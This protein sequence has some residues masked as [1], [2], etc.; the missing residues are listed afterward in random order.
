MKP[1]WT[2]QDYEAAIKKRVRGGVDAR[3][4]TVTSGSRRDPAIQKTIS[5]R[6][7]SALSPF[8]SKLEAQFAQQLESDV[9]AGIIGNFW[10]EPVSFKL[11]AGKRYRPDFMVL[12]DDGIAF[13]EIKGNWVKNKRDGLTHLKWAAQLYPIFSWVLVYRQQHEWTCEKVTV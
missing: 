13:Y 3:H 10:Y 12:T 4:T 11:A 2:E 6:G 1:H 5:R 8:R 7:E 9:R